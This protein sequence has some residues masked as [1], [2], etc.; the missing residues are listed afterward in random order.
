M[1]RL[2]HPC[3]PITAA[4]LGS[5]S[6]GAN[7]DNVEILN[8][9]ACTT[10][11]DYLVEVQDFSD[12]EIAVGT[13]NSSELG[14]LGNLVSLSAAAAAGADG[15]GGSLFCGCRWASCTMRYRHRMPHCSGLRGGSSHSTFRPPQKVGDLSICL[16]CRGLRLIISATGSG[17]SS[18][19]TPRR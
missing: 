12:Q 1:P 11:G 4:R 5:G 2:C 16:L 9:P 7:A 13:S 17:S 14:S 15:L 6:D 18:H 3:Y 8:G 19:A 10:Q